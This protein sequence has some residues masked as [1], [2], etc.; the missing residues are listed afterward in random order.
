MIAP[1]VDAAWTAAHL[2][3]VVLADVRWYLDGR[4]GRPEH[5][6]GHLP[7]AVFVELDE[8]LAA[9]ASPAAGRHPLPEPEVFARGMAELGIGDGDTVVA[10]DDQGGAV[11]ARLVWMLRVTGRDAARLDGGIAAWEGPLE[12]GPVERP[13]ASF[14][15]RPWPER[16]LASA[17]DAADRANA[18]IDARPRERYAGAGPDPVDPRPGHVP[19]ARSLPAREHVGPDGR[20]LDRETLRARFAEAGVEGARPV[21][22]YCGS[23]VT[24]CM[25]L[26]VLEHLGLGPG[27]LYAGSWSQWANDPER[28]AE[29]GEGA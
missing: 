21:V 20:L 22:S 9:P 10:Y 13:P 12:T 4:P 11:A 23:G 3:D 14:T 27:R 2:G 19:G 26:V 25:N 8:W 16:A 29:T 5:E 18:V 15:A 17:D 24:A 28:P 1:V 6:R 7:G